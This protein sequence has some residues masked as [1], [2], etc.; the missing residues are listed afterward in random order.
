[1]AGE[2]KADRSRQAALER[3][4]EWIRMSPRARQAKGKARFTAYNELVAEA[5]AAERRADKVEISI[6]PGP[7]LGDHVVDADGV[8]KGFGDRLLIED[9]R[10]RCRLVASS[11]DRPERGGQDHTLPDDRRRGQAR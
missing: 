3:E 9:C 7:R 4:L 6:P 8:I 1:M 11:G 2:D 5:E 10:S